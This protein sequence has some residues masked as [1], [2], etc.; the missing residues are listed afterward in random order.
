MVAFKARL[1][2][3]RRRVG[4]GLR[5]AEQKGTDALATGQVC[6][7]FALLRFVAQ[8]GH[9]QAYRVVHVDQ[10]GETGIGGRERFDGQAILDETGTGTAVRFGYQHAEKAQLGNGAQFAAR[11]GGAAVTLGSRG[12]N[13]FGGD[14]ARRVAD[15]DFLFTQERCRCIAHGDSL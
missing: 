12:G 11:P 4:A 6:Q 5:L 13:H 10:G 3:E 8:P 2:T 14:L 7:V 9:G 15:H 1:G